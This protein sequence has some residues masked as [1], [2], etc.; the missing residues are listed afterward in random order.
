MSNQIRLND[1]PVQSEAFLRNKSTNV[2]NTQEAI[3]L[4]NLLYQCFPENGAYAIAAPQIGILKRAFLAKYTLE[5]DPNKT[6]WCLFACNPEILDMYDP[7]E[8][9]QEGCLSFP[10]K[11][12]NTTRFKYAK[13]RY[14][15]E[16]MEE[17]VAVVEGLEAVIFQHEIDHLNG[18][19]YTDH[20]IN[21]PIQ[22]KTKIGRN[23]LCTCGS[24]KKYKKCCLNQ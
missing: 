5:N 18:I 17:R 22:V 13:V 4:R 15:N 19:L 3:A 21:K 12:K 7:I 24:G 9:P 14:F 11:P 6:N 1:F 16:N 10:N 20:I 2:E 8:F 23:E